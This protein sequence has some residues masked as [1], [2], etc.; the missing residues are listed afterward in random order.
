M[1]RGDRDK[2]TI[3]AV[4]T[5]HGVG[6]ISVIRISG[7]DTLAI[8]SK[9][10]T[11]LPAHPESHKVYFGN[12]KSQDGSEIDEV[13]ATYFKNGKS[14]TGEEVIEISCHG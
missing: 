9:L 7:P 11:F 5:P 14:F 2:D 1:V 10:C 4:S 6:G 13:L 12:I 3:C 8:V